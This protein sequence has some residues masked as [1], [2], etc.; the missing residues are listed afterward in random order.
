MICDKCVSIIPSTLGPNMPLGICPICQSTTVRLR[1]K[2]W[3]DARVVCDKEAPSSWML[4]VVGMADRKEKGCE[5]IS[6]SHQP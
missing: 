2:L 3:L 5:H 6:D 4:D 1:N